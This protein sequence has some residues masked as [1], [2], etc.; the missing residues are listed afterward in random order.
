MENCDLS[1]NKIYE[2]QKASS[3]L[4]IL[5]VPEPWCQR[6]RFDFLVADDQHV[7]D[8]L[9]LGLANLETEF[10]IPEILLHP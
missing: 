5:A 10:F 9:Q 8:L 7:R 4:N 2:I 3:A 1:G 6:K